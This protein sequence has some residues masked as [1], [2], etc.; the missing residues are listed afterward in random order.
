VLWGGCWT[1]QGAAFEP[2]IARRARGL[3]SF[4]GKDPF[5]NIPFPGPC[6]KRESG[7][8]EKDMNLNNVAH[9]FDAVI[10]T[11]VKLRPLRLPKVSL[12]LPRS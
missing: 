4:V 5:R 6:G 1:P 10:M 7:E 12:A 3:V 9:L 8:M 2:L 11:E